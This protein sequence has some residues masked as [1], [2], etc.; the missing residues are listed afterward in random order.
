M[1]GGKPGRPRLPYPT[2]PAC[3]NH[4]VAN[5]IALDVIS[6]ANGVSKSRLLDAAL[7]FALPHKD[8]N[9]RLNNHTDTNQ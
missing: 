6:R 2:K 8:F 9:P 3:Y 7:D 4:K 5:Q 1:R